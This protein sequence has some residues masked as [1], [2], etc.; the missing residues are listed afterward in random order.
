MSYMDDINDY[1]PRWLTW[2]KAKFDE[3]KFEYELRLRD[4]MIEA[5]YDPEEW[6]FECIPDDVQ[7]AIKRRIS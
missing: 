2:E 3:D 5:G 4:E 1:Y 6:D 7:N